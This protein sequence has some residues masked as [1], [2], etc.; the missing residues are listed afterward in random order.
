MGDYYL[1]ESM[2]NV[3]CSKKDFELKRLFSGDDVI[4]TKS[5][6]HFSNLDDVIK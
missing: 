5:F 1:L 6:Y 3:L 2:E 4:K